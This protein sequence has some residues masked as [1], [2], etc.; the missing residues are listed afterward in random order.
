[1][2]LVVIQS[3][4]I[5][6]KKQLINIQHKTDEKKIVQ[7]R[8]KNYDKANCKTIMSSFFCVLEC[9]AATTHAHSF[10]IAII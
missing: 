9:G 1:M 8:K 10:T 2:H 4:E 3:N 7:T 6:T 5:K